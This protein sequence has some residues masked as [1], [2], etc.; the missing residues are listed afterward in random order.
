M[1][2]LLLFVFFQVE[3]CDIC[4]IGSNYIICS[5]SSGGSDMN[6]HITSQEKQPPKKR[7]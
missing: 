6:S 5:Q 3:F 4:N 7:T 1:T 2:F